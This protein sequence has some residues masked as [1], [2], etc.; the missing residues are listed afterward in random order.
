MSDFKNFVARSAVAGFNNIAEPMAFNSQE[1]TSKPCAYTA[2]GA[3]FSFQFILENKEGLEL[4]KELTAH[5]NSR[6]A[7]NTQMGKIE[8]VHG[9]K[10]LETGQIKFNAKRKAMTNAGQQARAIR[11]VDGQKQ[12]IAERIIYKGAFVNV[13]FA[14]APTKNPSN[15]TWGMSLFL[16]A[17]QL[18]KQGTPSGEDLLDVVPGSSNPMNSIESDLDQ[19][20]E[21]EDSFI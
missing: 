15:N 13:Q 12:D 4:A 11:L 10:V 19:M 6:A 9:M 16:D 7:L 21:G 5:G 8:N 20:F 3:T 18:I 17:V 2:S 1:N 14:A